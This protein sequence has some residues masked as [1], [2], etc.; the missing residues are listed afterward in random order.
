[1]RQAV[2]GIDR[3]RE[4]VDTMIV[5]PNEKLLAVVERRTSILDVPGG[6]QRAGPGRPGHHRPDRRRA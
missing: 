3:L 5:I 6:R 2:D 4:Q 1:M